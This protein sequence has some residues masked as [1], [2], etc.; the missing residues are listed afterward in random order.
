MREKW[1]AKDKITMSCLDAPLE[2]CL[3]STRA[4]KDRFDALPAPVEEIT[5]NNLVIDSIYQ[6]MNKILQRRMWKKTRNS[7]MRS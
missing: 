5:I 3:R 1:C 7:L 4:I 2:D 6:K